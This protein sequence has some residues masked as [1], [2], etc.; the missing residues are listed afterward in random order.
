MKTPTAIRACKSLHHRFLLLTVI[1]ERL[2]KGDVQWMTAGRGI[3]H[4]EMPIFDPDPTKEE[5]SE[6][7]QLWV[8]LPAK[9][10]FCEPSYQER[11]AAE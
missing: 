10:K 3:M 1:D 5:N 2:E 8:D 11:K 9:D 4:S 6:G 7:L